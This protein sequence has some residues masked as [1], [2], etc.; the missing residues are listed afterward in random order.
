MDSF[1]NLSPLF[2]EKVTDFVVWYFCCDVFIVG[3]NVFMS[4]F[5]EIDF[6]F[7]NYYFLLKGRKHHWKIF[8]I[9]SYLC[10][11][12]PYKTCFDLRHS[13]CIIQVSVLK[14]LNYMNLSAVQMKLSFYEGV[15]I[16]RVST[17]QGY[18]T[19]LFQD[20]FPWQNWLTNWKETILSAWGGGG[21]I[22]FRADG[23][24]RVKIF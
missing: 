19:L 24:G 17:E 7:F 16:K 11:A 9:H 6:L 22:I 2:K 23:L 20:W 8:P 15:C 18:W 13:V 4:L 1:V 12:L 14:M 3:L 5:I 10:I 21:G